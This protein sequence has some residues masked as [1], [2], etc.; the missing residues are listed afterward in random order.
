MMP[1]EDN[2]SDIVG[3][4]LRGLAMS[5]AD[6]AAAA[7]I[8]ADEVRNLL[9]GEFD[10]TTV[11][12]LAPVL[13]LEAASLARIAR[14]A[15]APQAAPPPWLV[16]VTTDFG[17]M[18]VNAYVVWDLETRHA[19]IFD[20][21]ADAGPLLDVVKR[22]ELEVVAIFLTHSH[23]DHIG[24]LARLQKAVGAEA[25]SSEL[26]PVPGTK[27][28]RPGDL[29]NAGR[30]FIRTRLTCGH[31]PGGTTFLIEGQVVK[32]AIVG[33]ALF[34]GSIGGVR[35]DYTA[36]LEHIRREIFTL[37]DD[38]IIC[39]GHGPMTTVGQEKTGNPF[40]A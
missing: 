21:G 20:T 10:E 5:E 11:Q 1:L 15:F 18:T 8:S 38:T 32:V 22:N 25:W 6:A 12:A 17:G 36:A 24:A 14:G 34:A 31:S 23:A 2:F 37:P 40:F 30:H 13:G 7:G 16:S 27:R 26:E 3:K 33:D 29:F 4:A 35:G 9:D 39:P 28:F 19:A